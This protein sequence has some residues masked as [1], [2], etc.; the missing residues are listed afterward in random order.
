[1]PKTYASIDVWESPL[2]IEK[3]VGDLLGGERI[4]HDH[5]SSCKL[6]VGGAAVGDE[7]AGMGTLFPE[8]SFMQALKVAAIMGENRPVVRGCKVKLCGICVSQIKGL[9]CR[10]DIKAVRAEEVS[11]KYGHIF[12]EVE[13]DEERGASHWRRG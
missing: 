5:D 9:S 12:I 7:N 1:M 13:P 8:R 11:N 4:E 6:E 10:Q 3:L 2:E